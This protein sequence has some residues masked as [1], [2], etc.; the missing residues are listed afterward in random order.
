MDLAPRYDVVIAGARPA[1]AATA[2]LLA[3]AGARVLVVERDAPGTDT[4]STHALM[5]GAVML[6]H[7]WGLADALFAAGTPPVRQTRFV[8]CT[9]EI[10]LDIKARHGVDALLAPRRTVLD[11][12]LAAAARTAGA[13]SAT[14]PPS[15]PSR[16]TQRAASPAPSSAAAAPATASAPASS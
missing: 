11:P 15:T 16:A 7:K 8:Y 4:L 2:M 6:L 3:R 5:R 9:E 14:P 1:G 13:E 12:H 10:V